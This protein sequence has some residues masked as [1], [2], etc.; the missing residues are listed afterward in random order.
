MLDPSS[1]IAVQTPP[2]VDSDP[3]P[4]W[5]LRYWSIFVGQALSL[6]G[7]AVTQFVLIWW[8][9]DTTGSV[10]ALAAAG[11]AALLPQ[12]LLSPLGGTF[13][14]RYSRRLLM[15]IA[16]ATSAVCM[17][18]LIVLFQLGRIELWHIYTMMCI[19]SAMQAF[20]APADA[21]SVAMLVPASFLPRAAGLTQTLFGIMM[22]AAAPLGA[23]VISIMPIGMALS[24]DVITALLAIV[25]LLIFTIPQP[26][27]PKH[28]RTGLWREFRDGLQFVWGNPGLRHLYGLL[29]GVVLMVMPSSTLVPL[30]IKQHFGGGA[31]QVGIMEGLGGV[32]LIAGG[33]FVFALTPKRLIQWVLYGFAISCFALALA[34]VAPRNMFWLAVAWWIV[35]SFA[36][37]M[38]NAPLTTLIQTT[39]PNHMQGRALSLLSTVMGLAAPVGLALAAPLGEL[40]GVRGLFVLM[41]VLGGAV[42]LCGF[43]S[44][45]LRQLRVPDASPSMA[46]TK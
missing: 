24:I 19:R 31:A 30:L 1:A 5:A 39:I 18:T 43:L 28:Q 4:Q 14:D 35:S 37:A 10:A 32:G 27:I 3:G 13:A 8:I 12:A 6:F 41:G 15:I 40:I 44:P 25:P 22:I 34:A 2:A 21:A 9:T 42:S 7:S 11:L 29:A 16:D 26:K 38:G 17:I 33:L 45:A 36:F 46:S 23:L 20:Q